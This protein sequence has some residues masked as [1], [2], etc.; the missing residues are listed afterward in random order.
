MD[1]YEILSS[2]FLSAYKTSTGSNFTGNLND[3]ASVFSITG[4]Q[5]T[6]D[7]AISEASDPELAERQQTSVLRLL[8]QQFV[9]QYVSRLTEPSDARYSASEA[10]TALKSSGC[11]Y[12]PC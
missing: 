4:I 8:A 6:V 3:I 2:A 12:F 9:T 7:R 10:K 11:P 5:Q 1:V